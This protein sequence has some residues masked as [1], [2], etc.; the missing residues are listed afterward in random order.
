MTLLF[1]CKRRSVDKEKPFAC[2]FPPTFIESV[3]RK[4]PRREKAKGF[5]TTMESVSSIHFGID[6]FFV[7][8]RGLH[9]N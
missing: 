1:T 6:W 9:M 2:Y 7:K 5:A 3:E 8:R 4:A